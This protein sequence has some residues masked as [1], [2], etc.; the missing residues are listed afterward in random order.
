MEYFFFSFTGRSRKLKID[1]ETKELIC[2]AIFIN[3]FFGLNYENMVI[4]TYKPNRKEL[5]KR[6]RDIYDELY[7]KS[8]PRS[9]FVP[10]RKVEY[11]LVNRDKDRVVSV[12][13]E[14]VFESSNHYPESVFICLSRHTPSNTIKKYFISSGDY[15]M[16]RAINSTGIN[17]YIAGRFVFTIGND[18]K[19]LVY[20]LA[21]ETGQPF[22]GAENI[23]KFYLDKRKN[24]ESSKSFENR[25]R[26]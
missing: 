5:K 7:E 24:R 20:A 15:N 11:T 2:G 16:N 9:C 21:E 8:S 22:S 12:E 23:E 3:P 6:Y 13:A 10:T 4:M 25:Y 18:D 19:L 14:S 17:D 1:A 26:F